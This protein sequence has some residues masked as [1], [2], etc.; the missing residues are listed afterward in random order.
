VRIR[1]LVLLVLVVVVAPMARAIGAGPPYV[2]IVV[3]DGLDAA[4]LSAE[5]TPAL[6][7]LGHAETERG[8]FFPRANAVMPTTTNPNHTSII[9]G[10]YPA[11]HGIVANDYWDRAAR[12]RTRLDRASLV[13]V[14]T[15][16]DDV[17]SDPRQLG[18]AGIFGKWKLFELFGR[19]GRESRPDLLW[20][21]LV[22]DRETVDPRTGTAADERTMDEV[23]RTI[24]TRDP[25]LLFVNLPDLDHA[26]HGFGPDG[27]AA[28]KAVLEADRQVDRLV[29]FLKPRGRWR[30]TVLM[31]TADHGFT[32]ISNDEHPYPVIPFGRTLEH[33]GIEGVAAVS[34]GGVELLYLL[35]QDPGAAGLTED[36]AAKA[37][38]LRRLALAEK[39]VAEALYRLP[40]PLDGGEEH[41]LA[42]VHPDW[43][44]SHPRLGDV[45]LVAETGYAFADPFNPRGAGMLG[46]HGGPG[47]IEVPLL[48]TG[49][50]AGIRRGIVDREGAAAN[51]DVGMTARFLL[52]I[53]EPRYT[54]G[55]RVPAELR[56]RV[57]EEA[58]QKPEGETD[59]E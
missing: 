28:R 58:L 53:G 50:Y 46:S 13:E 54:S 27:Y 10:V 21:D 6:W 34:N 33:E 25:H 22:T 48:V 18:S 36:G 24:A 3:V 26:A 16:L 20:G 23:L 17:G 55:G 7:R 14:R 52:G 39:G 19:G 42:R 51:P 40:N 57:L 41:V 32:A 29:K 56:G 11:A 35:D 37:K 12:R 30:D 45:V 8:A 49:G 31:V 2:Y 38:T 44:W 1:R 15:L 4:K 9:T 59:G 5:L 43:R 47:Q